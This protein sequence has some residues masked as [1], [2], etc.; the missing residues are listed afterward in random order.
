MLYPT[1]NYTVVII[2]NDAS[3]AIQAIKL[4][5]F[6]YLL[7]PLTIDKMKEVIQKAI[8]YIDQYL[9]L[10]PIKYY[11]DN[12]RIRLSTFTGYKLIKLDELAF[13]VADG[14][15]TQFGY[16]NGKTDLSS[17]YLG[18][19]ESI[20]SEYQF[21]RISRY[22]IVN[23]K[24]VNRIDR[25]KKLCFIEMDNGLKGFKISKEKFNILEMK[26]FYY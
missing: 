24:K 14:S 2:A 18:K 5:V 21:V 7:M 19:I 6:D 9:H 1:G 3:N 23:L 26:N 15:Y 4:N 25:T 22:T 17:Y 10:Q 16:S 13:C 12:L 20:L 11:D 8:N